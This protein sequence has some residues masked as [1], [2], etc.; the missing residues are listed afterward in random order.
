MVRR[1]TAFAL[2][3][4]L[5]TSSAAHAAGTPMSN[6]PV[7]TPVAGDALLGT[8]GF[9]GPNTG[10][11]NNFL[12]GTS[13]A[14]IPLLSGANTW[15]GANVWSGNA[16]FNG[17]FGADNGIFSGTLNVGGLADLSTAQTAT[18]SVGDL[19]NSLGY[20]GASFGA[21]TGNQ[22]ILTPGATAGAAATLTLGGTAGLALPVV[23]LPSWTTSGRPAT[24]TGTLGVNTTTGFPE[25]AV[26]G[27][28]H[29]VITDQGGQTIPSLTLSGSGTAL[30]VTN[31]ATVGT[32][33][34][35]TFTSPG[36]VTFDG[37]TLA[38]NNGSFMFTAE[39]PVGLTGTENTFFGDKAGSAFTGS[40]SFNTAQGHN[41][42]GDGG[43]TG[44][45]SSNLCEGVDALR[46]MDGADFNMSILGAGG[47]S[48]Q[49]FQTNNWSGVGFQV[50][51]NDNIANSSANLS[52]LGMQACF[53]AAGASFRNGMCL[54]ALTGAALTT[55]SNFLII[56][57]GGNGTVGNT[58][59]ASGSGVILI[60]SGAQAVDTPLPGT[61]NYINIENILTVTGTNTPSTS[62][63]S[64]AGSLGAVA[65]IALH[66]TTVAALPTCNAGEE[67]TMMYVTDATAPAYNATLTGGGTVAVPVFCN[68]STWTSH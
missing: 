49:S 23:M 30:M 45:G 8:H 22:I 32:L 5:F 13:G 31:N 58:T 63:A 33:N 16:T 7:A 6:Y 61:S 14:T 57:G 56:G 64:F 1:F 19:N 29:Q 15:S 2:L 9:T 34:T 52:G 68:G 40:A 10:T 48:H 60:G 27:A 24:T 51:Y 42:C 3:L 12:I 18:L 36:G 53:G 11:T 4:F 17:A 47:A 46:D 66:G 55:A 65:G 50:F 39:G 26:G 25:I 20:G 35:I 59:F 44:T 54:G 38:N 28:F 67:G 37:G 62:V 21:A 43:T 41:A